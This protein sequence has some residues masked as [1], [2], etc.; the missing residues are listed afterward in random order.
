M[1]T[2]P[3]PTQPEK[4][5]TNMNEKKKNLNLITDFGLINGTLHY[6]NKC[7][8]VC[9]KSGSFHRSYTNNDLIV[10]HELRDLR[11]ALVVPVQNVLRLELATK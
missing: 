7:G 10:G 5:T 3:N 8:D 4:E 11:V 6:V 1:K 2:Q 9:S